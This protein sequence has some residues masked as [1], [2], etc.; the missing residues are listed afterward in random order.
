[1]YYQEHKKGS[2]IGLFTYV[3]PLSP[4]IIDGDNVYSVS[5]KST[6]SPC[7]LSGHAKT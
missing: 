1:M 6:I 3:K 7:N 5:N 4:T 2:N